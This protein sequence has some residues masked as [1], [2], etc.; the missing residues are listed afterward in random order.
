MKKQWKVD[1][2]QPSGY[3]YAWK[4]NPETLPAP[5]IWLKDVPVIDYVGKSVKGYFTIKKATNLEWLE[6]EQT[7]RNIR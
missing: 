3:T 2:S 7:T 1:N 6:H 4:G 5:W